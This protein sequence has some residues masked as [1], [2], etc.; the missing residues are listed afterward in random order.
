M[1]NRK[2]LII[3]EDDTE[4]EKIKSEKKL[5][6]ELIDKYL[7][8]LDS[9]ELQAIEIAKKFLETSFSIEKSIGFLEFKKSN[10]LSK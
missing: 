8:Q 1:K 10:N 3:L 4:E 6:K 5:E 2:K 9:F 7:N